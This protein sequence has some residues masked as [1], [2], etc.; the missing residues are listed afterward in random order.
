MANH[1]VVFPAL[2]AKPYGIVVR[3]NR[4]IKRTFLGRCRAT[5]RIR[6]RNIVC[7]LTKRPKRKC[8]I[9]NRAYWL[10]S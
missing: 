3:N 4:R 8:R 10:T 9:G 2:S 5:I 6:I 7:A 1:I